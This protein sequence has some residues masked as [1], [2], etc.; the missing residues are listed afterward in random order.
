MLDECA[1]FGCI[2]KARTNDS[3][4]LCNRALERT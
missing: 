2:V 4:K 1:R 3:L